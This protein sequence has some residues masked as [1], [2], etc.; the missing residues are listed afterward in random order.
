M[1]PELVEGRASTSSALILRRRCFKSP[2]WSDSWP[3]RSPVVVEKSAV[4]GILAVTLACGGGEVRSGRNFEQSS[5]VSAR[6]LAA[7]ARAARATP[8]AGAVAS[9]EIRQARPCPFHQSSGFRAGVRAGTAPGC[10]AYGVL[11]RILPAPTDLIPERLPDRGGKRS[12]VP[13]DRAGGG[14]RSREGT[15]CS[16]RRPPAW[17]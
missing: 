8:A 16:R 2:H 11:V 15:R 9:G 3:S 4:V 7:P 12:R 13:G 5:L 1:P 10:G 6:D 14:M 17:P